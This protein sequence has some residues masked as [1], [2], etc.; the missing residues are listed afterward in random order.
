[1]KSKNIAKPLPKDVQEILLNA[2]FILLNIL[3]HMASGKMNKEL[4]M[5]RLIT[6]CK[7][8]PISHLERL[9]KYL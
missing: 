6:V 1:M 2:E 5:Q 8:F 9:N 3:D 7:S 4:T